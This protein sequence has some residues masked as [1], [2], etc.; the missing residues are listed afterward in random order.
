MEKRVLEAETRAV[1]AEGKVSCN[2]LINPIDKVCCLTLSVLYTFT[3]KQIQFKS[4][5]SVIAFIKF[6]RVSINSCPGNNGRSCVP[7]A[8][9]VGVPK[10]G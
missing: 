5:R 10:V 3:I 4:K 8:G 7:V 6:I 2:K 1:E 9:L